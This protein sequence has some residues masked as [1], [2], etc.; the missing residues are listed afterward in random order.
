[1]A[2]NE[3]KDIRPWVIEDVCSILYGLVLA[4][5]T[6][7][8]SS[9]VIEHAVVEYPGCKVDTM[10]QEVLGGSPISMICDGC[11][12]GPYE[13]MYR[14]PSLDTGALLYEKD[15]QVQYRAWLEQPPDGVST[16]LEYMHQEATD[17]CAPGER[18]TWVDG[19]SQGCHPSRPWPDA[20]EYEAA[21]SGPLNASAPASDRACGVWLDYAADNQGVDPKWDRRTY[22]GGMGFGDAADW[23][24]YMQSF[25]T[26][27]PP[28]HSGMSSAITKASRYRQ[29]CMRAHS[30]GEAVLKASASLAYARIMHQVSTA[31]TRHMDRTGSTELLPLVA[32]GVL[33]SASCPS[34][35][36]VE[37]GLYGDGFVPVAV[38]TVQSS[39]AVLSQLA[40]AMR[41]LSVPQELIPLALQL[42]S[43]YDERFST[44]GEGLNAVSHYRNNSRLT[45]EQRRHIDALVEGSVSWSGS[46]VETGV[47]TEVHDDAV[48]GTALA[49]VDMFSEYVTSSDELAL[50]AVYALSAASSTIG[51][52]TL[53]GPKTMSLVGLHAALQLEEQLTQP[54]KS[55]L[56]MSRLPSSTAPQGT[57]EVDAREII[58]ER[59]GVWTKY[60]ADVPLQDTNATSMLTNVK[61][62]YELAPSETCSQI[63]AVLFDDELDRDLFSHVVKPDFHYR[64]QQLSDSVADALYTVLKEDT[65]GLMK[66][67]AQAA[68]R[69]R[70]VQMRIA[71]APEHTWGEKMNLPLFTRTHTHRSH[72]PPPPYHLQ[73]LTHTHMRMF[74]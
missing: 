27:I 48:L 20:F 44:P 24:E 40:H 74:E 58:A 61:G 23:A 12:S 18:L 72:C 68:E 15:E 7:M 59:A 28:M 60:D 42:A 31:C 16:W 30:A 57:A 71:G 54:D 32:A 3:P 45:G 56:Y 66:D 19:R 47:E 49:F 38:R 33:S 63:S 41:L 10:L 65:H 37:L 46:T 53:A 6:F 14:D 34:P 36:A 52:L 22:S 17:G 5:V 50:Q 21:R 25:I 55:L 2:A 11:L 70:G 64:I 67:P 1:M 39:P 8:H 73:A 13:G 29:E 9:S 35:L 51:I 62:M 43:V 4:L 69:V 26:P